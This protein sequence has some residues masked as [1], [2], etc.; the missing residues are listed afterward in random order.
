MAVCSETTAP[1]WIVSR[2]GLVVLTRH[3][4]QTNDSMASLHAVATLMGGKPL[5]DCSQAPHGAWHWIDPTIARP[6]EVD[7][8]GDWS[9]PNPNPNP[10]PNPNPEPADY[11]NSCVSGLTGAPRTLTCTLTRSRSTAPATGP[12]GSSSRLLQQPQRS[13]PGSHTCARGE[14]AASVRC[15]SRSRQSSSTTRSYAGRRRP[16][17]TCR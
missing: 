17:C 11:T 14:R 10:D 5:P 3:G 16:S 13:R 2:L 12:K 1:C 15:A 4:V 7:S 6:L 9:N 8:S